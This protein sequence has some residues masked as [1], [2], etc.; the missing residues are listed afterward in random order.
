MI[1]IF[2][3]ATNALAYTNM[4]FYKIESESEKKNKQ[5]DLTR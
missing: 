2:T 1:I 5:F 3:F 4:L